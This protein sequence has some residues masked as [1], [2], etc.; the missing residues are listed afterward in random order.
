[1]TVELVGEF[2]DNKFC[3]GLLESTIRSLNDDVFES[4]GQGRANATTAKGSE[5]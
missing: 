5:H 2:T 1:M 3:E 4:L